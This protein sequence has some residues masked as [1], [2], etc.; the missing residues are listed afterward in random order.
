MTWNL[1]SGLYNEM[2]ENGFC[3]RLKSKMS[4]HP[5]DDPGAAAGP[6]RVSYLVSQHV[7]LVTLDLDGNNLIR[8]AVNNLFTLLSRNHKA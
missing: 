7:Q 2:K 3:V 6:V 4:P 5:S 8:T 1:D